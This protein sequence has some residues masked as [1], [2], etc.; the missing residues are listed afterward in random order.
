MYMV[1]NTILKNKRLEKITNKK[2]IY[3]SEISSLNLQLQHNV[4]LRGKENFFA[5]CNVY[6]QKY[7]YS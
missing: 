5:K 6:K 7:N 1:V 2:R 4:I 3:S